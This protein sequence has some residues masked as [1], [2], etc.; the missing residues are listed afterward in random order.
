M[1]RLRAQRA[2][3]RSWEREV[4]VAANQRLELTI[5]IKPVRQGPTPPPRGELGR[6]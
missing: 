1:H 2:G 6:D 5:D 4:Q 3:Y